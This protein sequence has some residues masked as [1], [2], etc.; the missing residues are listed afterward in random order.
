MIT[1]VQMIIIN[2]VVSQATDW[3]RAFTKVSIHLLRYK[4]KDLMVEMKLHFI[5]QIPVL[6]M[7]D[8]YLGEVLSITDSAMVQSREVKT[9]LLD[10][11][12]QASRVLEFFQITVGLL[13]VYIL[14]S[15]I[16]VYLM[17]S[18]VVSQ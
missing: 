16:W 13:K 2:M 3:P 1:S 7:L 17:E 14:R 12:F 11:C 15:E 18:T 4:R 8:E 6:E 9:F 5:I 10:S